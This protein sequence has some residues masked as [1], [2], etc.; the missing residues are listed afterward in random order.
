MS[1]EY[2]DANGD[3]VM[4]QAQIKKD[5]PSSEPCEVCEVTLLEHDWIVLDINGMVIK[6]SKQEGAR[7]PKRPVPNEDLRFDFY[8]AY[9]SLGGV[10]KQVSRY[11]L[12]GALERYIANGTL[13]LGVWELR[14]GEKSNGVTPIDA[15]LSPKFDI[16]G[17]D[18]LWHTW[19]YSFTPKDW[20]TRSE[21]VYKFMV[22]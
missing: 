12:E 8:E 13:F 19:N 7:V 3:L 9:N 20:Q 22:Y 2:R 6:C 16:E 10:D 1:H 14:V 21:E 5:L 11:L 15:R 4:F 17:H 18:N